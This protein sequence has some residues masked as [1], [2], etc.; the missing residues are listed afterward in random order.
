MKEVNPP[1]DIFQTKLYQV[2]PED[3]PE[4]L[5]PMRNIQHY[6]DQVPGAS[7][8]N[9]PHYMMNPQKSEIMKEKIDELL[10]KGHIQESMSHCAVLALLTPKKDGTWLM[11]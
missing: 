1:V 9:L 7:L 3:L 8:P 4:D 11:C 2:I 6:I 10:K 5:P